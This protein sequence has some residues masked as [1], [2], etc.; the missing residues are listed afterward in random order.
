[1]VHGMDCM[2]KKGGAYDGRSGGVVEAPGEAGVDGGGGGGVSDGVE[3]ADEAGDGLA[4]GIE[5]PT[6]AAHAQPAPGRRSRLA[7]FP[8]NPDG[9]VSEWERR[10]AF[11]RRLGKEAGPRLPSQSPIPLH[12]TMP[13]ERKG[14]YMGTWGLEF[15]QG[16][17]VA[18]LLTSTN[19]GPREETGQVHNRI[20]RLGS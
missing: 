12:S 2:R 17:H 14:P 1:M 9:Q 11:Y 5:A 7:H 20:P 4:Q 13:P 15:R 10:L 19:V 16:H 8:W 18:T 3:A 6:L